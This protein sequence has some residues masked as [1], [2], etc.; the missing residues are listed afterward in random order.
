MS[1]SRSLFE[2]ANDFIYPQTQMYDFFDY[3]A[4][5]KITLPEHK[6][7]V[8]E[9]TITLKISAPLPKP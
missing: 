5:E 2:Q 7:Q 1:A 9:T 4:G 3:L 6:S 8:D